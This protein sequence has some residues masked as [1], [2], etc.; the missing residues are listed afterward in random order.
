[1]G[2]DRIKQDGLSV[3]VVGDRARIEEGLRTLDVPI[4]LLDVNGEII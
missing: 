2:S 3:L 1:M 4:V